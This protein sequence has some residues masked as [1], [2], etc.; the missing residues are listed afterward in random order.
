MD[1]F[2]ILTL[3]PPG[4]FS[5]EAALYFA[6]ALGLDR[7][8]VRAETG[9]NDQTVSETLINLDAVMGVVPFETTGGGLVPEVT[10]ALLK[11]LDRNPKIYREYIMPIQQSFAYKSHLSQV[12]TVVTHQQSILQCQHFLSKL[13]QEHP[14]IEVKP[15]GSNSEAMRLASEDESLAAIGPRLAA[16]EIYRLPHVVHGV[17]DSANNETRFILL[18]GRDYG[19]PTGMD[20]TTLTYAVRNEPAALWNAIGTFSRRGLNLSGQHSIPT[21]MKLG[22]YRMVTEVDAHESYEAMQG[23]LRE[24]VDWVVPG[25][26]YL[27]GSY[28]RHI[29]GNGR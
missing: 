17:Q 9:S 10:N 7:S 12:R 29:N 26:I 16:E 20:R 13:K 8:V 14:Y 28:P 25:S 6:D 4:S 19:E 5:H 1:V 18:H 24:L 23:A 3:G 2:S 15:V 21:R 22:D 11:G 27:F